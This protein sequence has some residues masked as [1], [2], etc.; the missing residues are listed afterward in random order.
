MS[1]QERAWTLPVYAQL[2]LEQ[3]WFDYPEGSTWETQFLFRRHNFWLDQSKADY[4]RFTWLGADRGSLLRLDLSRTLWSERD[5]AAN[6]RF[7]LS[8]PGFDRAP[9]YVETVLRLQIGLVEDLVLKTHSRIA[10]L[11]RFETEDPEIV[12]LLGPGKHVEA[13]LLA[14]G[15]IPGAHSDYRS[16]G[17]HFVELVYTISERSDVSLGF[18]VDPWVLYDVRNTYM[19]IG[20]EQFLFEAGASPDAALTDP[21]YL[22]ERMGQAERELELERRL[23]LEARIYF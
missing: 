14:Q 8:S 11:R 20:W 9:R 12:A 15:D 22:G 13:G 3:S 7:S 19:D 1:S 17:S 18:G 4:A 16:F 23:M 6:L 5:L 2:D 10:T 21:L